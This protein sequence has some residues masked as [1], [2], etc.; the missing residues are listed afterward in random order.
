MVKMKYTTP[1]NRI[2]VCI[3]IL[4]A[5]IIWSLY[6][7]KNPNIVMDHV[8]EY[9]D[10]GE[11]ILSS[12]IPIKLEYNNNNNYISVTFNYKNLPI[13]KK[14]TG[15][16]KATNFY[17]DYMGKDKDFYNVHTYCMYIKQQNTQE[18]TQDEHNY[19]KKYITYKSNNEGERK[20]KDIYFEDMGGGNNQRIAFDNKDNTEN[21]TYKI[22]FLNKNK[23][24]MI[25]D[26]NSNTNALKL[27]KDK[28]NSN[29]TVDFTSHSETP[30]EYIQKAIVYRNDFPNTA[31]NNISTS[32]STNNDYITGSG[33]GD[34]TDN[35]ELI[36]YFKNVWKT[37]SDTQ[38]DTKWYG[39]HES[40]SISFTEFDDDNKTYTIEF[41]TDLKDEI[42]KKEIPINNNTL[43]EA[44]IISSNLI[45]A[46]N[47]IST[48][49]IFFQIV[50][51]PSSNTIDNRSSD[52]KILH[53][54]YYLQVWAI[55]NDEPL[56]RINL[57]YRKIYIGDSSELEEDENGY[58]IKVHEKDIGNVQNNLPETKP[59]PP[60][61]LLGLVGTME[62]TIGS[63]F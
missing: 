33:Y 10:P 3:G 62:K 30:T 52:D 36:P 39:N 42:S 60:P 26:Y 47:Q 11:D 13:V 40:L 9:F 14:V 41:S 43:E 45:I 38:G 7:C 5:I 50:P 44:R 19:T 49:K 32:T 56:T 25:L 53:P 8:K 24:T 20:N 61:Q 34:I 59:E 48:Y 21:T 54:L 12:D 57:F 27:V 23:N 1:Y 63:F 28:H 4:L 58:F 18:N 37:Q 15:Q 6:Q 35:N 16:E 46:D 29:L 2:I 22:C 31:H 51:T 55:K 17:V